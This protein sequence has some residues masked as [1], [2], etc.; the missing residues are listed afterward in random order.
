MPFE[1]MASQNNFFNTSRSLST[2][3][4]DYT[5]P[6]GIK[7][8]DPNAPLMMYVSKMVP[9]SDKGRFFAFGR[10]FSGCVSTG[11]KVKIMGPNYVKGK[12]DDICTK[13]IQR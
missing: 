11:L 7:N 8:C 10:V 6:S 1:V 5:V 9:S 3:I 4:H 13:P 12:K 2:H